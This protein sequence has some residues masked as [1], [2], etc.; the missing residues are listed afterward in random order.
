MG[1]MPSTEAGPE[2]V[3]LR[4]I[5]A[6]FVVMALGGLL[7]FWINLRLQSQVGMQTRALRISEARMRNLFENTPV[8][9]VEEDFFPVI[10]WLGDLRRQG[11]VDLRAHLAAHP[12]LSEEKLP[13]VRVVAANRT[14]LRVSGAQDLADYAR[15]MVETRT[16]EV[17]EAFEAQLDALWE[18]ATEMTRE[19]R[20]RG[21]D[22]LPG[23]SLMHWSVPNEDGRPDYTRVQV[24]FT[25][26]GVLRATEEKL[27]DVEDRWRLAVISIN[28][29]IWEYNFSTGEVFLSDRWKEIIGFSPPTCLMSAANFRTACIPMMPGA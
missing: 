10:D 8:A 17:V 27:R 13:L 20:Y 5:G 9:I 22:G 19:L 21:V 23:H 24:A 12:G 3:W 6:V 4:W 15:L 28:A 29:G 7:V 16:P 26:L 11:V 14:V 1:A 2:T 25:D 18:G